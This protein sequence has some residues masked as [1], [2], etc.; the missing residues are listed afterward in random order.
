VAGTRP[1]RIRARLP[2]SFVHHGFLRRVTRPLLLVALDACSSASPAS[3]STDLPYLVDASY[4]RTE[5]VASLVNPTD[6]YA[7][8]RLAHYATGLAGDWERLPEWNPDVDVIAAFELDAPGGAQ[9]SAMSAT[10]APL[11]LPKDVASEDDPRLIALGAAAFHRYPVELA[12]YFDVALASRSVAAR[13]G[14]WVD[15][16]AG[17][18]GLVRV[19]MAD[20]SGALA[21]T[22][23]TC[24][25]APV[26]G[27][28]V[29][30]RPDALLDV[31]AARG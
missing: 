2:G 11:T 18:G 10:A 30:G 12:P 8:L 14:V 26:G 6:G 25:E 5:L 21:V 13:Y 9:T 24:H 4:R 27:R 22:C 3:Q 20:G 16:D 7:Q 28:L 17:A 31:G 23:A 29:P 15:D 19:R 1:Q